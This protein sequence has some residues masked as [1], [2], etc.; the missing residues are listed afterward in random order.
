ML[1]LKSMKTNWTTP[2]FVLRRLIPVA[3]G[4]FFIGFVISAAIYSWQR[5]PTLED[6]IMSDLLSRIDNPH[7]Y[8]FS[9]IASVIC[10]LFLLPAATIF[11]R[12]WKRSPR[13]W[14]IFGAWLYRLGLIATIV[15]GATTP[16]QQPY[17]LFHIWIALFAFLS[18]VAGLTVSLWIAVYASPFTRFWLVVLGVLQIC[19]L[20]FLVYEFF[21]FLG[22]FSDC[23]EG[24][25]GL[26]AVFE[27]S[28]VALIA[29]SVGVLVAA[30]EKQNEV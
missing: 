6:G 19:A 9:A 25:R 22:F 23:F 13:R 30:L 4:V 21:S 27:W 7:G 1:Q 5:T 28:W 18:T 26:L 8:L 29:A 15:I 2:A 12:G 10:S 16:L 17:T 24:H 11:Q 20:L 3:Y 14:T